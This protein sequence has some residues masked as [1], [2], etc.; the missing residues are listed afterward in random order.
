M[1][2]RVV[3]AFRQA[4]ADVST[5]SIMFCVTIPVALGNLQDHPLP[6]DITSEVIDG[7]VP[8]LSDFAL[9]DVSF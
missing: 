9:T 3:F 8:K 4:D 1:Q 2:I 5:P 6:F 7:V